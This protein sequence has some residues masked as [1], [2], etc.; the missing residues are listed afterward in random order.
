MGHPVRL[1]YIFLGLV[2]TGIGGLGVF[3][4][5]L[6]TTPFLLLASFFFSKGSARFEKWFRGTKL[7]Q[8]YLHEFIECRAMRL[9]NKIALL[10]F[11]SSVLLLSMFLVEILFIR[12]FILLLIVYKYY[13]FIF[14]IKTSDSDKKRGVCLAKNE[15]L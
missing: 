10:S 2:F 5:V 15:N 6:P 7:Y 4:P 3:L 1:L 9:K 11:A 13:Y 8:N 14:K 12:V